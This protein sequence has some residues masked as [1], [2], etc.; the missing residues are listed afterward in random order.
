M[1]FSHWNEGGTCVWG[2]VGDRSRITGQKSFD[3]L[4]DAT[5]FLRRLNVGPELANV[6]C[7]PT[8][9]LSLVGGSWD[10]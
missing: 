5:R 10:T 4:Y 7:L 3:A 2:F 6:A 1:R 9:H 8:H